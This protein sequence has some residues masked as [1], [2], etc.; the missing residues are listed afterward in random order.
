MKRPKEIGHHFYVA[1][2][3][4][5]ADLFDDEVQKAMILSSFPPHIATRVCAAIDGLEK[6][7][8]F[9]R[10]LNEYNEWMALQQMQQAA[11]VEFGYA[12]LCHE[13]AMPMQARHYS[14]CSIG[15]EAI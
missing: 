9:I 13:S 2:T 6:M 7:D 14:R 4:E 11:V 1:K 3:V 8:L 15:F 12:F 10:F 5:Y